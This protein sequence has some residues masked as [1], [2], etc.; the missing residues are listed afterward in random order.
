MIVQDTSKPRVKQKFYSKKTAGGIF[1]MRSAWE[2]QKIKKET[3]HSRVYESIQ[4]K[5]H[6]WYIQLNNARPHVAIVVQ[7]DLQEIR[8]FLAWN[9]A[10]WL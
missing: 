7:I 3:I 6:S 10:H 8:I 5:R 4:I 9:F 1:A 2:K